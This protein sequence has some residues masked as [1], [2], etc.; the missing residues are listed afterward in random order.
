MCRP[1]SFSSRHVT[2]LPMCRFFVRHS[3]NFLCELQ[4][5]QCLKFGEFNI[6]FI[7]LTLKF[8]ICWRRLKWIRKGFQAPFWEDR[9]VIFMK[10]LVVTTIPTEKLIFIS[11]GQNIKALINLLFWKLEGCLTVHLLHE[12]IW[13]ANLMQQGNFIDVFLAR[14]VSGTYAHHQEL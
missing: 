8:K 11:L 14:H 4:H 5:L 10:L 1:H 6:M 3:F 13:N 7:L 12:I 9:I 2:L